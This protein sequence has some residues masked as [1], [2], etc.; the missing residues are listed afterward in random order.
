VVGAV[1]ARWRQVRGVG[2]IRLDPALRFVDVAH[3]DSLTELRG[4]FARLAVELG[5]TDFNLSTVTRHRRI[6]TQRVARYVYEHR[7]EAG[8]SAF[9]GIRYIARH[10]PVWECWAV[11]ADRLVGERLPVQGIEAEDA[12]LTTAAAHFKLVVEHDLPE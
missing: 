1:P 8:M 11:F 5:Y 4:A 12:G 9:A 2:Q 10:N 7:T 6:L 3:P